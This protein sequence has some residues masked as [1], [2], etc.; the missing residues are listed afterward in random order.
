MIERPIRVL[1][2][3]QNLAEISR[4][5]FVWVSADVFALDLEPR[6]INPSLF[7]LLG[8]CLEQD[9]FNFLRALSI[10]SLLDKLIGRFTEPI[11]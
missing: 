10:L 1:G 8:N 6:I 7:L 3:V 5:G 2:F 9:A 4:S 11:R